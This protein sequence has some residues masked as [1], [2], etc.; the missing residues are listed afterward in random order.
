M[1]I[2]LPLSLSLP[3]PLSVSCTL[4]TTNFSTTYKVCAL[5]HIYTYMTFGLFTEMSTQIGWTDRGRFCVQP[6]LCIFH[7]EGHVSQHI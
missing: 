7:P 5:G 4:C 1:D 3:L 2:S 6:V